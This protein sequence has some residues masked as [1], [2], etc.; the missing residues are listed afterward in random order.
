M[1]DFGTCGPQWEVFIKHL[2]LGFR[3]LHRREG[4]KTVRARG[5]GWHILDGWR[6]QHLTDTIGPTHMLTQEVYGSIH[7]ACTGW[8]RQS[9]C[10]EKKQNGSE[11]PSQPKK[12]SSVDNHLQWIVVSSDTENIKH[13]CLTEYIKGN[14]H[15]HQ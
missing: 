6:K 12:L 14:P 10:T 13:W 11:L 2:L 9:P 1:R 4:R 3:E 7:M 5:D 15:A 8:S